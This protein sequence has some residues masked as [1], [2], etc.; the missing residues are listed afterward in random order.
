MSDSKSREIAE[1][2]FERNQKREAELQ[3]ALRREAARHAAL[4]SNM[5]R[6]RA[7]RLQRD[8]KRVPDE[9]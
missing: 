5:H 9:H 1:S 6:L 2:I 3:D 4:V 8:S 7:L